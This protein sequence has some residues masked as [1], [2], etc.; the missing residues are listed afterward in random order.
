M[1]HK[2]N[3]TKKKGGFIRSIYNYFKNK[4][5][6]KINDSYYKDNREKIDT[7]KEIKINDVLEGDNC[8]TC[9]LYHFLKN[10]QDKYSDS[11]ILRRT[12]NY[13]IITPELMNR[14]KDGGYC[15][16]NVTHN[17]ESPVY[18][19]RKSH[20]ELEGFFSDFKIKGTL[21]S[22]LNLR[23]I[24]QYTKI[25]QLNT[26][27]NDITYKSCRNHINR[28]LPN[29]STFFKIEPLE[30][31]D[32]EVE[33]PNISITHID[34]PTVTNTDDRT[35]RTL[36]NTEPTYSS[37]HSKSTR[38]T[39]SRK[40]ISLN[41]INKSKRVRLSDL[42][43]SGLDFNPNKLSII[44]EFSLQSQPKSRP[45][46]RPKSPIVLGPTISNIHKSNRKTVKRKIHNE[47]E[48]PQP[49]LI[50]EETQQKRKIVNRNPT[51]PTISNIR[52]TQRKVIQRPN[53]TIRLKN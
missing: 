32:I 53:N 50:G 47:T 12:S 30:I 49:K 36:T 7:F 44:P 11:I 46:S 17:I 4:N 21:L 13:Y 28:N 37:T 33:P 42:Y 23:K 1:S 9:T 8:D 22:E 3:R 35:Y 48:E 18:D 34:D 51:G 20:T 15:D 38:K 45:K 16:N 40:I 25:F 31:K 43:D 39:Q 10:E 41:D 27:R 6:Q 5:V 2:K 26:N 19:L 29:P 52:T 14:M 24:P